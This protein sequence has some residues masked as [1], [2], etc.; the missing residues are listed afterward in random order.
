MSKNMCT[1]QYQGFSGSGGNDGTR[2]VGATALLVDSNTNTDRHGTES[3][4]RWMGVWV[5]RIR[6]GVYCFIQRGTES[7][8]PGPFAICRRNTLP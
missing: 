3:S 4:W 5:E 8:S 7:G 2:S 6:S 1:T